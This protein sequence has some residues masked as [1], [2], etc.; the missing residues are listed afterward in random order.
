MKG[1]RDRLAYFLD[2]N[3][4]FGRI[5]GTL[6]VLVAAN[7][8]FLIFSMPVITAGPALAAMY[9]IL[10]KSMRHPDDILRPFKEFWIGLKGNFKQA[11]IVWLGFL[12]FMAIA[13][14]DIDYIQAS[15]N[16]GFMRWPI[17]LITGVVLILTSFLFPVMAAFESPLPRLFQNALYFAARNPIRAVGCA[18]AYALPLALTYLDLQRLPLYAFIW[19]TVGFAVCASLVSQML[20]KDFNRFLPDPNIIEDEED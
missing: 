14:F 13:I 8:L 6:W 2:N 12:A 7:V 10:L 18:A 4:T 17:Y 16:L 9:H 11:I 3:S 5:T 1:F 15:G 19:S 20:I